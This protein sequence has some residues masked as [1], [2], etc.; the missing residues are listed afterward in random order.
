MKNKWTK[1]NKEWVLKWFTECENLGVNPWEWDFKSSYTGETP[2]KHSYI[3]SAI[4][5]MLRYKNYGL[6]EKSSLNVSGNKGKFADS[7]KEAMHIYNILYPLDDYGVIRGD[8]MNSFITTFNQ[9]ILQSSN[10]EVV[11]K[12]IGI[13]K[14]ESLSKQFDILVKNNNFLKFDLVKRNLDDL[15][16][17]AKLTHTIGNFTVLPHWMNTGRYQFSKDYWDITLQSLKDFIKPFGGWEKFIEIYDYYDYVDEN[18]E[19]NEFWE[20][21]FLTIP[22]VPI[23]GNEDELRQF[24]HYVNSA[25]VNRGKRIIMKLCNEIDSTEYSFLREI[26]EFNPNSLKSLITPQNKEMHV[27]AL[28]RIDYLIEN[29]KLNPNVKKYFQEGKIYYSYLT[30][31]GFMGSIDNVSYDPRYES[32]INQFEE[33]LG[34][35][36]YHAIETGET[37]A[38]LFVSR[39]NEE[40]GENRTSNWKF[41]IPDEE[42]WVYVYV[43][44]FNDER[45]VSE[46]GSIQISSFEDS[47]C[48]V[49]VG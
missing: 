39:P 22:N 34:Y 29:F 18:L 21:H 36:V 30:A 41:E 24:L 8:T 44:S 3:G 12:E 5:L 26:K 46:D 45:W 15:E 4:K 1:D 14:K 48:L 42:G 20:D 11:Y 32:F 35:I 27:E 10:K 43:K 2:I 6:I 23:F 49:R 9:C 17:F 19:V 47:G 7:D 25:I 37:L 31:G 38:L 28:N 33:Q 40:V 13:N 16:E